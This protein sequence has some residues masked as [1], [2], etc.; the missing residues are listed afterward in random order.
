MKERLTC[1]SEAHRITRF[2]QHCPGGLSGSFSLC[3]QSRSTEPNT[4]ICKDESVVAIQVAFKSRA[5][6][7]TNG[8]DSSRLISLNLDK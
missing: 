8:T 5:K 3:E 4:P 6:L 2:G 1:G 7:S